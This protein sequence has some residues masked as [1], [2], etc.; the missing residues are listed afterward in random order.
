VTTVAIAT[1]AG[2]GMG[3]ACVHELSRVADHV[4]LVDRDA[5]S[6]TEAAGALPASA[7]AGV[8]AEPFVLDVTDPDGLRRL[9][10]RTAEAGTLRAV[11][12]AAGI[13]PTMADWRR[14]FQVDLI[15]TALLV[16]ALRPLATEGTA[17]VCFASMSAVLR[18]PHPDDQAFDAIMADPLDPGMLD[19]LREAVG[20]DIEDPDWAYGLAKRGVK[21]LV[22][23]EAVALGPQ[24]ARICSVS[25]GIIAT[26]Q[27]FQ[28]AEAHPSMSRMVA[29]TPLGRM[30]RPEELAA[31]VR[32][33]V[34]DQASFINGT[35]ILV[36]GGAVAAITA[37]AKARAA[38]G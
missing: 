2:R 6:V 33:L 13:S 35:D 22:E 36:D 34:S 27:G 17:F 25:P 38:S 5:D 15:G 32:F 7:P 23:R 24:G 37:A 18:P 30:G 1:G 10:E 16:D 14:I 4:I 26:P 20:P 12:H 31:V 21:R 3:L 19:R 9:A 11:A 28:E 8:T 29:L